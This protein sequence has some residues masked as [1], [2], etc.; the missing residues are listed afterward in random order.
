MNDIDKALGI[1]VERDPET[2]DHMLEHRPTAT[3]IVI[4]T[5]ASVG[6]WVRHEDWCQALGAYGLWLP[7]TNGLPDGSAIAGFYTGITTH[8]PLPARVQ[9]HI[10]GTPGWQRAFMLRRAA[11]SGFSATETRR[12][13]ALLV[14]RLQDHGGITVLNRQRPAPKPGPQWQEQW[15]SHIVDIAMHA[16]T[17]TGMIPRQDFRWHSRQQNV[18][19]PATVAELIAAGDLVPGETLYPG[20]K[21]ELVPPAVLNADGTH[22]WRGHTYTHIS[23]AAR[24]ARGMKKTS[25]WQ[26]WRVRRG[27]TLVPLEAIRANYQD[28]Q[29]AF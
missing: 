3:V 24:L 17:L 5:P 19:A 16:C 8:R 4:T 18:A 29:P 13:E 11:E 14:R 22:T 27:E 12:L 25:G 23:A 15:L 10:T 2:G 1:S 21:P 20:W 9:G 6:A 26:Y 7:P 28:R